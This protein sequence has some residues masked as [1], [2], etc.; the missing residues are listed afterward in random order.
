MPWTARAVADQVGIRHF[1]AEVMPGEK[2]N[3]VEALQH[4]GKV[5]AMVGDGINDSQ[6]LAQADVSNCHGKRVGYCHGRGKGDFDYFRSERDSPC[7]CAFAS[8]GAGDS[9][10]FVLGVYL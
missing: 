3:F 6:A 8:D 2:A 9:T 7:Y 10:K 1:K 4:E 5:V